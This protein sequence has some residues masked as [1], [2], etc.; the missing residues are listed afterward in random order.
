LLLALAALALLSGHARAVGEQVEPE[1]ADVLEGQAFH[2]KLTWG[3]GDQS[4]QAHVGCAHCGPGWTAT[5]TKADGST[6]T[7]QRYTVLTFPNNFQGAGGQPRWAENYTITVPTNPLV[8][9]NVTVHLVDDFAQPQR[10]YMVT[11]AVHVQASGL[12]PGADVFINVSK[13]THSGSLN[14]VGNLRV[15]AGSS[16]LAWFDWRIPKEAASDMSCPILGGVCRNFTVRVESL[17]KPREAAT[18]TAVPATLNASIVYLAER[19]G[20]GLVPVLNATLDYNRT[21]NVTVALDVR[22]L[23][24]AALTTSDRVLAGNQSMNG[25]LALAVERVSA[26]E[27]NS[28]PVAERVGTVYANWTSRGWRASWHIPKNLTTTAIGADN[29]LYRVR[30]LP[31]EDAWGNRVPDTNG[32]GFRVL[33]L[34]IQPQLRLAPTE[35]VERLGNA[36]AVFRLAYADGEPFTNRSASSTFVAKLVDGTGDELENANLTYLGKGDWRARYLPKM[37]FRPLDFYKLRIKNTG[38][39]EGNEVVTTDTDYFRVVPARP[40]ITLDTRV[41]FEARNETGGFARGDLVDVF[42]TVKY[43]DGS[44]FNR[45]R[46][47]QGSEAAIAVN[48]TKVDERGVERGVARFGLQPADDQGHWQGRYLLEGLD[49]TNPV[50]PWRWTL[51]VRD[52]EN[53]PNA[54]LT[55]FVRWVHGA[56][57]GVG[58]TRQPEPLVRAGDTVTF[59]FQASYPNGTNLDAGLGGSGLSVVVSPWREGKAQEP[60][61]RLYPSYDPEREDWGAAWTTN[62]SSIVGEYVLAVTG[63]DV[64]GNLLQSTESRHVTVFVDQLQRQVLREPLEEMHRGEVVLV[65]FDGAEGDVGE[66]GRAT[67]RIEV[68]KWNPVRNAWEKELGDVRT[69]STDGGPD[70]FGRFATS[71]ATNL[72]TYRLAL[73]ARNDQLAVVTGFSRSFRIMPVELER[74]WLPPA[75]LAVEA[76]VS[77]GQL[78]TLPLTRED[79]DLVEDAGVYRDGER[80]ANATATGLVGRYDVRWRTE[81]VLAAGPYDVIVRGRDLHNNS[82]Q[83]PPLRIQLQ[84][85][86]VEPRVPVP[87]AGALQRAERFELRALLQYPDQQAVRTGAFTARFVLDG[88]EVGSAPLVLNRSAWLL[89]WTPPAGAPL[90][91]YTVLVDGDDGLGDTVAGKELFGFQL[92][93]GVLERSFSFQRSVANRTELV[94]WVLPAEASDHDMN[95]TLRDEAGVR[96]ALDVDLASDGKGYV[97]RWRPAKDEKLSRYTLEAQ[98]TD[99]ASNAIVGSSRPLTLRAAQVGAVF[100]SGPGREVQPGQTARWVFQLQYVDGTVLPA[101]SENR[102]QVA[103]LAGDKL[104]D[105]PPTLSVEDGKWVVA[106][107]PVAGKHSGAYRLAVGGRDQYLNEVQLNFGQTFRIQ[108][109]AIKEFLGVPGLEAALVPVVL[110]GAALLVRRR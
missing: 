55:D 56:P 21:S 16:G 89:N 75:L 50:G 77:K 100:L 72:G 45:A 24:G 93:E 79:G 46:L 58:F 104:T 87:P 99:Q 34:R 35:E 12:V 95:F 13:W 26:A 44:P 59:R 43:P 32:T 65:V 1:V 57:L 17:G 49:D 36:T 88:M 51:D 39:A 67:P 94:T 86:E 105:P 102:P 9:A 109:G 68:Q 97:V 31:Q 22:Y 47:P 90:G 73:F 62:R 63:H 41:G 82:F 2:V 83:S 42:A 53:P 40:R 14:S 98:G 103:M 107:T 71:Q 7:G 8:T 15:K 80:V 84:G 27:G 11:G 10:A 91:R 92:A 30:L 96:K 52:R 78:L 6:P 48:I 3:V 20:E 5:A 25:T 69:N 85:V 23:N 70:H 28:P 74:A 101:T 76:N 54:N 110:L 38:D 106:W 29:P 37:N 108:E 4:E 81:F 33:P 60:V 64:F 66:E 19:P 61:A 18:F